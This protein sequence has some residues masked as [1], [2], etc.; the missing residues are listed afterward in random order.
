MWEVAVVRRDP[1]GTETSFWSLIGDVDLR[2]A[3]PYALNL[4]G[5]DDRWTA[6][7]GVRGGTS[8]VPMMCF[9][10]VKVIQRVIELTDGAHIVGSGPAFDMT[11]LIEAAHRLGLRPPSW[12]YHPVDISEVAVGFLANEMD[13]GKVRWKSDTLAE[14]CGVRAPGDSRHTA[15]GDVRWTMD[16]Y[17]LMLPGVFPMK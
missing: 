1:D 5:F 13:L 15:Y 3:D 9:P 8:A 11:N 7:F 4:G 16:W 17:D 12:H 2:D 10:E 6:E 14:H